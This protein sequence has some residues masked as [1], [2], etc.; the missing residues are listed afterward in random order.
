M[1]FPSFPRLACV[2][3]ARHGQREMLPAL[4]V[5][6]RDAAL[7][8]TP[9]ATGWAGLT[10]QS[11]E[12]AEGSTEDTFSGGRPMAT[13]DAVIE[14]SLASGGDGT[15]LLAAAE[16]IGVAFG[17]AADPA[18][19]EMVLGNASV[20]VPASTRYA[21]VSTYNRDRRTDLPTF[22][23]WWKV[24]HVPFMFDSPTGRILAPSI[25]GYEIVG[26]QAD[27]SAAAAKKAGYALAPEIF[28]ALHIGDPTEFFELAAASGHDA[29][30]ITDEEGFISYDWRIGSPEQA[31]ESYRSRRDILRVGVVERLSG[32]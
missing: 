32:P 27:A 1:E 8:A 18:D 16:A 17:D 19:C 24:H 5:Q 28:E 15:Q 14:I 13:L 26:G 12:L 7:S 11:E 2:V 4:L 9:G 30:C 31:A 29:A 3:T 23:H 6:A 10:L 22:L 25:R 21:V 20:A